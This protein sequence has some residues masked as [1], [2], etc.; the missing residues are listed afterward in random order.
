MKDFARQFAAMFA[1][2]PSVVSCNIAGALLVLAPAPVRA[3]VADVLAVE[4]ACRELVCDFAV[5][6]RHADE[7][8]DHYADAFELLAEDRSVLAT[9][10]LRHP[11]VEEQPFTRS[12]TGVKLPAATKWLIVRAR[13]K[14]HQ[15]GGAEVRV[16]I[17]PLPRDSVPTPNP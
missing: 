8:W 4:V 15:Y 7:G 6:L 10:V 1:A 13:D 5:T 12:L 2:V 9:R 11:H 14:L 17:P 3:G 16:A